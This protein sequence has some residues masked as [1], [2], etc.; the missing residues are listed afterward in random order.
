MN[1]DDLLQQTMDTY[2][3]DGLDTAINYI[4]TFI[5]ENPNISEAYLVRSEI[6]TEVGN[7]QKA[8][9][10]AEKAIKINPKD[11]TG[12]NNR[13]CI[14]VK[15]G[16]DVNKALNDFN[17]AIELNARYGNAY[18]NR[19]NVYLKMREPQK[20]ISD[21]T[22]AIELLSN[23]G[24]ES[25]EPYYNRGLAYMNTGETAKALD[26]YN[27]VIELDP[28]NAEA[29]AKRGAINSVSGNKQEAIHD[30][31]EFLRLDPDNKNAKLVRDEL[32]NVKSGKDSSSAD[33]S[34]RKKK[35]IHMVV[36]VVI[37]GFIGSIVAV[38]SGYIYI[39]F[40]LGAFLGIG[41]SHFR[42]FEFGN[43]WLLSA[44]ETAMNS[45]HN[46]GFGSGLGSL[47]VGLIL[48]IPVLLIKLF[49]CP[50]IAIYQLIADK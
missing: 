22:K 3:K 39:G 18:G 11:A 38:D 1:Y 50:F 8:L 20:A 12:Y 29:Y 2:K 45:F 24:K 35:I 5:N 10:D 48:S 21:C 31:E 36:G 37:G 23:T 43:L 9:D 15:S 7:F 19:A 17:K 13:G 33:S 42:K 49:I 4:N 40:L 28:E 44:W 6:Y 41:I 34:G 26:D 30:Y 25:M 27:K 16:D 46:E 47:A 32:K 14:F